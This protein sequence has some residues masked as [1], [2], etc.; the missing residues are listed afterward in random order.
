MKKYIIGNTEKEDDDTDKTVKTILT[1]LRLPTRQLKD[2]VQNQPSNANQ[3][4]Q[5]STISTA[6][7]LKEIPD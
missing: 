1:T 4:L 7:I 3:Y 5:N 2:H 6:T